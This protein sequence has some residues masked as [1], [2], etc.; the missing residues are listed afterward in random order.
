MAGQSS[1]IFISGGVRS[2]KSRFAEVLAGR[3]ET[4][5]SGQLHYVAAGQPGDVEMRE[6]IMRH[7]QDRELSGLKW[8]TWEIPRNLSPLSTLL[9]KN[10]IVLLDCLTTLLNNEFFHEDGQWEKADFPKMIVTKVMNELRQVAQQART[11][12][13]VSNEVLGEAIGDGRLVFT[14]AQVLG[15]IHQALIKEADYAYLVEAGLPILMKGEG[16]P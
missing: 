10:D 8:R 2:G 11:F 12:I 4:E 5:Y 16:S 15:Q 6:R 1:L 14:Y 13:V 7:Q 9:T 3:M